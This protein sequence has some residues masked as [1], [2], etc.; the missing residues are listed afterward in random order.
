MGVVPWVMNQHF[1]TTNFQMLSHWVASQEGFSIKKKVGLLKRLA[2]TWGFTL[3]FRSLGNTQE[4]KGTS[5]GAD[6]PRLNMGEV[7]S[8]GVLSIYLF[9]YFSIFK[10]LNIFFLPLFPAQYL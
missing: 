8:R 10:K 7:G 9:I 4:G 6:S 3:H 1:Y 5:V 2:S